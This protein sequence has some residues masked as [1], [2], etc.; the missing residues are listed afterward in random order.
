MEA[1][2]TI[3]VPTDLSESSAVGMRYALEMAA[4]LHAEVII[5]HVARYESDFPYPLGIGEVSSAYL[6]SQDFEEFVQ[7]RT[8]ALK[9]FVHEKYSDL[10]GGM[11]VALEVD[12]GIPQDMILQKA[13]QAKVD[14][15]VMSTHGRTGLDHILIGSVTEHVVRRSNCPVFSIRSKKFAGEN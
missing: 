15:I 11:K 4:S 5:Y 7:Q 12:I 9:R 1:I 14:L 6:P 8:E 3:L 13:E 2:N 10:V